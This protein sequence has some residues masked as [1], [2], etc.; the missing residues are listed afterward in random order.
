M[1]TFVRPSSSNIWMNCSGSISLVNAVRMLNAEP[2]R[3]TFHADMGTR[4]HEF[5]KEL[6]GMVFDP[7]KEP[8][9]PNVG[10]ICYQ[11]LEG[12][13]D[14]LDVPGCAS[15]PLDNENLM[16]HVER[17]LYMDIN[18][19]HL[20]GTPDVVMFVLGSDT[21][22]TESYSQEIILIDYKSGNVPISASQNTQLFCYM[23]LLRNKYPNASSYMYCIFQPSVSDSISLYLAYP[24]EIDKFI[25]RISKQFADAISDP[26]LS[27]GDHCTYC[28]AREHCAE[29]TKDIH[30]FDKVY[31]KDNILNFIENTDSINRKVKELT[32]VSKKLINN[33]M[34][35]GYKLKDTLKRKYWRYDLP[36]TR[37]KIIKKFGGEVPVDRLL[38]IITPA[39][40]LKNFPDIDISDLI[41]EKY[42]SK[43]ITKEN[44]N[45]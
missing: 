33:N 21:A 16:I 35:P 37:Q 38:D 5:L 45:V 40:F 9:Y 28:P 44:N 11:L 25:S 12:V 27:V 15:Y 2:Q 14:M 42:T 29:Y 39:S 20:S 17:P 4:R 8:F 7:C 32:M 30:A 19:V 6:D 10:G 34:L 22:I 26:K 13:K 43:K 31:N 36:D 3:N 1:S 41:E 24:S 18:G 23:A